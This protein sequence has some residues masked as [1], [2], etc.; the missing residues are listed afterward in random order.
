[1]KAALESLSKIGAELYQAAQAAQAAGAAGAAEPA[2]AADGAG[3]EA[4]PKPAKKSEGKVVDADV[5][6]VDDEKK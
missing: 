5:E 3:G 2:A 1:M 6:I 4:Q